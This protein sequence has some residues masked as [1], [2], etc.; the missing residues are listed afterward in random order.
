M[1]VGHKTRK[2][3]FVLDGVLPAE[4]FQAQNARTIADDNSFDRFVFKQPYDLDEVPAV[5]HLKLIVPDGRSDNANGQYTFKFLL[6]SQFRGIPGS[7]LCRIHA[8]P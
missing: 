1:R 7:E 5:A 8:V 4:G 2:Q 3:D 6:A